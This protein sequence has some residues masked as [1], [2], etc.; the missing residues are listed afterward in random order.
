M[1]T[2][3]ENDTG[4][5]W[6]VWFR[7]KY[8]CFFL[9]RILIRVE[10]KV[11][12]WGVFGINIYENLKKTYSANSTVLRFDGN[13]NFWLNLRKTWKFAD[14]SQKK[15]INDNVWVGGVGTMQFLHVGARFTSK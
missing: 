13:T 15:S 5:T 2:K 10:M 6:T 9:I 7:D 12:L 4:F 8:S 1:E 3:L 14:L 11:I